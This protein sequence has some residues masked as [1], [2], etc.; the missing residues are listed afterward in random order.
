MKQ[1][2]VWVFLKKNP[3]KV[4]VLEQVKVRQ[5]IRLQTD[6]QTALKGGGDVQVMKSICF[7]S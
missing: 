3:M 6:R 4:C 5:Q 7:E 1:K 2:V